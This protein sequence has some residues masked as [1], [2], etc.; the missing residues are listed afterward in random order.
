MQFI[1]IYIDFVQQTNRLSGCHISNDK[2][3]LKI[4]IYNIN[5]V[6]TLTAKYYY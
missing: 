4:T 2:I 1:N 5:N 6:F 3:L